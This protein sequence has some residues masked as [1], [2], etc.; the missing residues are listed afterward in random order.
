[1]LYE[2]ITN[3]NNNEAWLITKSGGPEY[4][5]LAIKITIRANLARLCDRQPQSLPALDLALTSLILVPKNAAA[6][7]FPSVYRTALQ[8]TGL[9]CY[10][11]PPLVSPSDKITYDANLFLYPAADRRRSGIEHPVSGALRRQAAGPGRT[12][13]SQHAG[14]E[15]REGRTPARPAPGDPGIRTP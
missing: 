6:R 13:P 12:N 9:K 10:D 5:R 7:H 14:P 4:R 1:M 15:P 2:V 11:A 8:L 3:K